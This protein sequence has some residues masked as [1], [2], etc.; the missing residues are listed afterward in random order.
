M[1]VIGS[2]FLL[3]FYFNLQE[4]RLS[5]KTDTLTIVIDD[6]YLNY[7]S[8]TSIMSLNIYKNKGKFLLYSNTKKRIS[9]KSTNIFWHNEY[10][11]VIFRL[12]NRRGNIIEEGYW[13]M[14]AWHSGYYVFYY[15]NGN[16]KL[17]GVF[18]E[19]SRVGTFLHYDQNG[20]LITKT[21]YPDT[22]KILGT[23]I[24]YPVL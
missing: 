24:K 4:N 6:K 16:K 5:K 8:C 10:E 9:E 12:K 1:I 3:H 21:Y 7:D 18:Y 20:N 15:P 23:A 2:V 13:D 19:N 14:E 17:I 22:Y 11:Y